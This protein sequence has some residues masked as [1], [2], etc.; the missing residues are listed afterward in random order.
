MIILEHWLILFKTIFKEIIKM[1][2]D[3]QKIIQVVGVWGVY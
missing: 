3:T 1:E 2:V